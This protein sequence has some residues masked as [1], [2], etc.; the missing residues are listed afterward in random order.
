MNELSQHTGQGEIILYQP[1][2]TVRLEVRLE[3][4]TVWLTTNQMAVLFD[5]EESNIRRHIINVFKEGELERCNNVQ[6]IHVNGVKKPV[7]YYA[8]DVI[9]SV[10]YRV[11]SQRGTK[12]RQWANRVL[13][14]YLLNGYAI[15]QRMKI[16]KED[17]DNRFL[18][19][20]KRIEAV[21]SKIDFFVRS[22][23]PPVEGVLFE[24]QIFDAY[25]LVEALVKSAKR[26]IILIDNYVDAMRSTTLVLRSRTS[27]SA[28]SP[29]NSWELTRTSF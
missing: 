8:L 24:G 14:D 26:E 4:D 27:A 1:D 6:N 5:R 13:K 25:K 19:H 7:P 20:E 29:S 10:G 9:I 28:S 3:D 22:S 23:L 2:E 21:E 17:I 15:N 12:F 11:K 16:I 18:Q